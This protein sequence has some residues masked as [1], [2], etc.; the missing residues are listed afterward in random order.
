[1][2]MTGKTIFIAGPPDL[3]DEEVVLK[4]FNEKEIKAQLH[5]QA[6]ALAGKEGVLLAI[7]AEDGGQLA[8]YKLDFLPAWDGMAAAN[9]KLY[10]STLD[11]Q[12]VCFAG[13]ASDGK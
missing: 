6:A 8:E 9:G 5:K 13:H 10:M 3:I 2:T 1:M 12:V 4:R 11:G 7:S